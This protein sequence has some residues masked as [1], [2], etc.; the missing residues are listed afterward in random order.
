MLLT[1][2][3][4]APPLAIGD[5]QSHCSPADVVH[6]TGTFTSNTVQGVATGNECHMRFLKYPIDHSLTRRKT[7]LCP[8]HPCAKVNISSE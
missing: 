2:F 3:R 8:Q 1:K 4:L 6:F 5:S 7:K